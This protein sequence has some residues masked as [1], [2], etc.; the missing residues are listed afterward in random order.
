MAEGNRRSG[1]DRR[2]LGDG[3]RRSDA[4]A[5]EWFALQQRSNK[6]VGISYDFETALRVAIKEKKKTKAA[7]FKVDKSKP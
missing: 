2:K 6:V 7:A 1:K 5:R 4:Y 3:E